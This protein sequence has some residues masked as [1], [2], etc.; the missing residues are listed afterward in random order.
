MHPPT[1][2]GRTL[3]ESHDIIA[4]MALSSSP[5]RPKRE[6]SKQPMS[7]DPT[8]IGDRLVAAPGAAVKSRFKR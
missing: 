5:N 7:V 1:A 4:S 3:V 2:A 8:L 6:V